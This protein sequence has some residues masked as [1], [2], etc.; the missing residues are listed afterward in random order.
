MTNET[1]FN[2]KMCRRRQSSRAK[3]R[4]CCWPRHYVTPLSAKASHL[5]QDLPPPPKREGEKSVL[6]V[7]NPALPL[8]GF[9]VAIAA[10]AAVHRVLPV[11]VRQF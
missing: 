3:I 8:K 5:L 11:R 4:C 6:L 1:R 2:R 9:D 7:G 10:L